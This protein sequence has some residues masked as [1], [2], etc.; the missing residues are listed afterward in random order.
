MA[1]EVGTLTLERNKENH[2]YVCSERNPKTAY[3]RRQSLWRIPS[4]KAN[5]NVTSEVPTSHYYKSPR[6]TSHGP[7]GTNASRKSWWEEICICSRGRLLQIHLGK[8]HQG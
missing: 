8:F 6:T 5:Q 4:W 2:L 7:N 1:S 3:Q